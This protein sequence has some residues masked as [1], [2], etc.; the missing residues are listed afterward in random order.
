MGDGWLP[1]DVEHRRLRRESVIDDII[2]YAVF[3]KNKDMLKSTGDLTLPFFPLQ[4]PC[5]CLLLDG[6]CGGIC[7][8]IRCATAGNGCELVAFVRFAPLSSLVNSSVTPDFKS[9]TKEA[10]KLHLEHHEAH[11]GGDNPLRNCR[12]IV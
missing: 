2:D 3:S 11:C 12:E 10:N 5:R 7:G 8:E 4:S 9:D 6:I 1:A